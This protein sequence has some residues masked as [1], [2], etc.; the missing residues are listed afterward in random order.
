MQRRDCTRTR[1]P[2]LSLKAL[3]MAIPKFFT[4]K[5]WAEAFGGRIPASTLRAEIH[6]GRMR[7]YRAR[8]GC[9]APILVSE[10]E[11]ERWLRDVAGQRQAALS[12]VQAKAA[13]E[14]AGHAE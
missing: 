6:A 2:T 4:L 10:S 11:M 5:E 7:C 14:E 3:A 13:V 8:P 12:P 9:N 1:W